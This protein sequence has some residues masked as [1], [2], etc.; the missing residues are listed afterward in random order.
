MSP[1]VYPV[2]PSLVSVD[3]LVCVMIT[4]SQQTRVSQNGGSERTME[5]AT[6]ATPALYTSTSGDY[7]V[8]PVILSSGG[9]DEMPPTMIAPP[10]SLEGYATEET[11]VSVQANVN[12]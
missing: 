6:Q 1:I 7:D 10:P 8:K 5:Y 2:Y 4:L 12:R 3:A 9:H 11:T